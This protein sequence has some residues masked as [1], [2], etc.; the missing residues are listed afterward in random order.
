MRK[1]DYEYNLIYLIE[2]LWV[3][4]QFVG[5]QLIQLSN[6]YPTRL[7]CYI[8]IEQQERENEQ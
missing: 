5:K 7:E 2:E 3:V 8:W 1:V 6:R 4:I